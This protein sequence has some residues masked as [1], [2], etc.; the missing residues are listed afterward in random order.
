MSPNLKK[1]IRSWPSNKRTPFTHNFSTCRLRMTSAPSHSAAHAP[2]KQASTQ[3]S[4]L[5]LLSQ[6]LSTLF[7]KTS[8][9]LQAKDTFFTFHTFFCTQSRCGICFLTCLASRSLANY[10]VHRLYSPRSH[11]LLSKPPKSPSILFPL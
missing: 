4:Q 3:A 2:A 8:R 7:S 6:V 11:A 10:P 5:V 1:T 9:Q